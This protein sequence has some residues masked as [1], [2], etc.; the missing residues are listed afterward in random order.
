VIIDFHT[1][2]FH[3]E[4]IEN[5]SRYIQEQQW[6]ST[7]YG[8]SNARMASAKGLIEEMDRCGVDRAVACGFAWDSFDLYVKTNSYIAD[9]VSRYPDRLI[10]FA[11]V[12]PL[13]PEAPDELERCFEMGLGGVGELKAGG[14]GF[15]LDDPGTLEPVA[16]VAARHKLPVLVHI[17][18]PVG[19]QYPGKGFTSPRKGY[20]LALAYP[21]LKLVYAHWGGGLLFYELMPDVQQELTN[22]YYDCSANP[23]LYDSSIFQLSM[24]LPISNKLLF[25]S[26]YPLLRLDDCIEEIREAGLRED[27]YKALMG[28]NAESLLREVDLWT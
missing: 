26:D 12:P 16:L 7:L 17:S 1:H 2:I 24:S 23:Y 4:I 19:K 14:Q 20:R 3:P 22:V 9:A 13:H 18:E 10:G 27:D 5:R 25:A 21:E 8:D 15:D 6:F 28:G 11:N